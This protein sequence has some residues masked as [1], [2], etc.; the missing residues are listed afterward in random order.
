V[1]DEEFG[2]GGGED[3]EGGVVRWEYVYNV[4]LGSYFEMAQLLLS[5]VSGNLD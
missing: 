3:L 2:V 5:H 1:D 4:S